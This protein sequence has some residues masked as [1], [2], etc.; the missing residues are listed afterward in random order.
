MQIIGGTASGIHL[1]VPKGFQVR[2]TLARSRKSL[3]DSMG[4]FAGLK[5]ADFFA[6]TGAVGLE[7]ASRG[8]REVWFLESESGN[9]KIITEN[10]AK[11]AKAGVE[12]EMRVVCS[13]VLHSYLRIPYADII[14]ADPPYSDSEEMLRKL[15]SDAKF[16]EWAAKSL[17]VWELP[18]RRR[19]EVINGILSE[20]GMW[21]SV[22]RRSFGET[23]FLFLRTAI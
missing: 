4:S 14:F 22:K 18:G 20:S 5:A 10:I 21:K 2:P 19:L 1:A 3:F 6:G 17:L 11:V 8:A 9:C 7:A 15:L 13:N 16:A 23:E 12:A